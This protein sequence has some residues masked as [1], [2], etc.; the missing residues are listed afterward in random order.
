M[1]ATPL[2]RV[3]GAA[4][5]ASWRLSA[6]R[7]RPPVRAQVRELPVLVA[8]MTP[9]AVDVVSLRLVGVDGAALP[10]WH[11]GAHRDR[12]LTPAERVGAMTICVSR[13]AGDR[14]VLDL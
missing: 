3:I 10:A 8:D 13:A 6:L 11:P 4:V 5:R 1:R 7:R 14:L 12:A 2:V 9:E